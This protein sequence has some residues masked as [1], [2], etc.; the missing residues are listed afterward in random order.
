MKYG[1]NIG[2]FCIFASLVFLF[3]LE[4]IIKA[5]TF[6]VK[7]ETTMKK[8]IFAIM[9]MCAMTMNVDAQVY[10]GD[11]WLQ[12]PTMDIYDTNM[13]DM[14]ARALAETAARRRANFEWYFDEAVDAYERKEW[15]EVVYLVNQALET[16]YESGD[17]YYMRGYAYEQLGYYKAA[18][19]DY[20]KSKKMNTPGAA[21]ALEALKAKSKRR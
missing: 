9:L 15:K 18:K 13:M 8:K 11:T 6:A 5:P 10:A 16:K 3:C 4:V 12:M 1:H 2:V 19:K 21:R 20:K 14:Y 7:K 17:I